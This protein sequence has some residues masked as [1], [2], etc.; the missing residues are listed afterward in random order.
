MIL[1]RST[2]YCFLLALLIW[3]AMAFLSAPIVPMEWQAPP[4]PGLSGEFTS[5]NI[6]ADV[7]TVSMPGM[8][9]EDVA[10]SADGSLY[11][12]LVD[13]RIMRWRQGGAPE[14]VANTQGRPLGMIFDLQNRLV[15][16][17]AQRGL[18]RM[19]EQGG[20]EVLVNEYR[21]RSLK[22]VDDVAIAA[23]GTIWFSDASQR[24]GFEDNLLDFFEGSMTGRLMSYNPSSGETTVHIE[25]LF[26]ANG[27][28]MG[29]KDAYV[30]V[31]ETG[32]GRVQRYWL[33]GRKAHTSDI[34]IEHLPGTPDNINFDGSDTFWIAM[35]ALRDGIDVLADKPLIRRLMSVLPTA[36][37]T[38][39]ANVA[40][41]VVGVDLEGRVVANLQDSELRYNYVTSA[42]PCGDD[43]WL[44]SLHMFSVARLPAASLTN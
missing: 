14:E 30:L 23:D 22:F 1:F 43:M 8:G 35:P 19:D 33:T 40:S 24:F 12:G 3:V 9:P 27:V 44:G 6:L 38:S 2:L 39:A 5:N 11:T 41:L 13:G 42:T 18:I 16:A 34:F 29:P 4:N 10:C 37:L 21:G 31:N 26:F 15:I 28:T 20:F 36:A 7:T 17:D 32:L 25:G